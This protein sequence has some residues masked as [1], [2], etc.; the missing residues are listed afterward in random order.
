METIEVL[1]FKTNILVED[2]VSLV[3]QFLCALS[4]ILDCN[5]DLD[6]CDKVL[7]IESSGITPHQII[8]QVTM[9]GFHCEELQD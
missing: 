8:D 2:E 7:R 9:L 4:P 5:V 3:K 6:D 1:V